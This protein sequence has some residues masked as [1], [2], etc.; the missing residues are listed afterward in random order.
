MHEAVSELI[1]SRRVLEVSQLPHVIS[2]LSVLVQSSGKKRLILDLR[3]ANRYLEKQK[4]KYED[5][6]V[7]SSYFQKSAFII[8]FYLKSGY[9]HIEIQREYQTL[10]GFSW[11]CPDS[12]TRRYF[13][14]TVLPFGLSTA[15]HIFTKLLR[16]ALAWDSF[17]MIWWL[18]ENTKGAC[19]ALFQRIKTD[20]ADSGLVTNEDKCQWEPCQVLKWLGLEWNSITGTIRITEMRLL[21]IRESTNCIFQKSFFVSARELASFVGKIIS[22]VAVF[23]N[24]ARLMTRYCSISIAAAPD[25]D[26]VSVLDEYCQRELVF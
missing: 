20:L 12:N 15:P 7:A 6:K 17:W 3:Y 5:W 22:A 25:W 18:T 1:M 24:I 23:G 4:I 16:P 2:P 10:L 14:F 26:S 19:Q 11:K 13:V 9:H 8:S 21:S